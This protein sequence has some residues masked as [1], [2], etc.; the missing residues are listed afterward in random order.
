METKSF[1]I[2]DISHDTIMTCIMN[3]EKCKSKFGGFI[4]LKLAKLREI[5][6]QENQIM[7]EL[8]QAEESLKSFYDLLKQKFVTDEALENYSYDTASKSFVKK[9]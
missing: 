4:Y 1:K 2:D 6:T 9:R 8:K 5:E 7:S 3:L